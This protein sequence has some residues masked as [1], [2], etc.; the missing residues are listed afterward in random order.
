M[1]PM[2][3]DHGPLDLSRVNGNGHHPSTTNGTAIASDTSANGHPH[4]NGN[5]H[6]AGKSSDAAP[7]TQLNGHDDV[8]H[9]SVYEPIAIIGCGMRLPGRV[10]DSEALWDMLI[11]KREGRVLVPESRYHVEAFYAASGGKPKPGQVVSRYG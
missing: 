3:V 4:S 6:H 1:A 7:K 10:N 2:S 5:C 8:Q 11:N 9:S